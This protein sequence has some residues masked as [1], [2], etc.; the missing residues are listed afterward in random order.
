MKGIRV[1]LV[2]DEIDYS[3]ILARRLEKRGLSV[4]TAP[5][6]CEAMTTLEGEKIDVVLLDIK[7]PGRDGVQL[8]G[9]I[10]RLYPHIEVVMLTAHINPD[11]V[12]SSLAMGA[13]DYLLKPADVDELVSKIGDANQR[14]MKDSD[15][16]GC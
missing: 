15:S 11:I 10:K 16:K 3:L 4:S 14:K 9:E 7:M 12:I 8:L 13:F 5:G 1:L 6:G 2:D